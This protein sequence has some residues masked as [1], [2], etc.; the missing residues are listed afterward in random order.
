M[1]AKP[2]TITVMRRTHQAG[3]TL[4]ELLVTVAAVILLCVFSAFLLRQTPQTTARYDSQR[5]TDVALLVQAITNYRTKNNGALPAGI[6]TTYKTIGS[7][8]GELDLC[9]VLVP[10]YLTDVPYDPTAGALSSL[11]DRCDATDQEYTTGYEVKRNDNGTQVT[12]QAPHAQGQKM[13]VIS[14]NF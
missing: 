12:V 9:K 3:F 11:D 2:G 8:D 10:K 4:P 6:T 7:Q 13:I 14:K 5:Q 1:G